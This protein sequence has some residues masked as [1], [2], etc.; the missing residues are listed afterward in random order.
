MPLPVPPTMPPTRAQPAAVEPV[1]PQHQDG[2][3]DGPEATRLGPDPGNAAMQ[4]YNLR[5][6]L[7]Q[8]QHIART[9]GNAQM[10]DAANA[11]VNGLAGMHINEQRT[12]AT[13]AGS[14]NITGT[15][16][17]TAAMHGNGQAAVTPPLHAHGATC[18]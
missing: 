12:I 10:L 6:Q 16:P 2:R 18:T 1:A 8:M 4:M 14:P 17:T 11:A 9:S 3:A 7:M 13:T 5:M 15:P